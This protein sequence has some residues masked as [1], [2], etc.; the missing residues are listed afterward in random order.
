MT[1]DIR[2]IN[3]FLESLIEHPKTPDEVRH[4]D[5]LFYDWNEALPYSSDLYAAEIEKDPDRD[6]VILNFADIQ[7][8]M[9]H[10]AI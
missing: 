9:L 5:T 4:G 10:R 3:E 8:Q 6:F 2:V 1:A 7:F